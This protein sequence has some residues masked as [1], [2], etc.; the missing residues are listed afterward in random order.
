[1]KLKNK[2]KL[3]ASYKLKA[4]N[5]EIVFFKFILNNL[6]DNLMKKQTIELVCVCPPYRMRKI[7]IG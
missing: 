1:M 3:G 6:N 4:F 2:Q 7:I 5:N